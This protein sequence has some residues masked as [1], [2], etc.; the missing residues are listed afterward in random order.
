MFEIKRLY[1]TER[2][3]NTKTTRAEEVTFLFE[4][5][6]KTTTKKHQKINFYADQLNV[7]AVYLAE[8]VKKTTGS[9]PKKIITEYIIMEAKSLLINS[10]KTI[11]QIGESLGFDEVSNFIN[12][13]KK[14]AGYTPNQF[15]KMNLK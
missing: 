7:S 3:Q 15:K 11:E 1:E 13:F 9:T 14:N 5:I 10:T 8:C 2:F 4:N 6:L 12:F